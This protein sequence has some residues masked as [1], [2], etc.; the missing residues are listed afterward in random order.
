MFGNL[1]DVPGVQVGH[2]VYAQA[3]TGCTVVLTPAG[4]V[5]GVDVRGSAPGTRETDPLQPGRIVERA[6]AVLLTGGSAYGLAAADGVMRF[7]E[8]RGAGFAVGPVRVPIVPAAVIFDLLVGDPRIRPDAEL[9][10]LACQA[11]GA[12]EMPEGNVG[13]GLGA[14]VGKVFGMEW[15]MKGGLGSCS[16][17]LDSGV[18]VG[19]LAVVNAVGEVRDPETGRP[20][21]GPINPLTGRLADLP[22]LLRSGRGLGNLGMAHTTLAVVATDAALTPP[23]AQKLAQMA[24]TGLARAVY[25]AHTLLDGDVVF[26]LSTGGRTADLNA[27]GAVAADL[28]AAAI[29]RG[30]RAAVGVAGLRDASSRPPLDRDFDPEEGPR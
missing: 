25:P 23:Q 30:V 27:V 24:Q 4:A 19:A 2:A 26:A 18:T 10:Y 20:I 15:A 13:A 8:E 6:H 5:A 16:Q 9:G 3:L 22:R 1:T 7:L 12:G 21:A 28:V 29:A 17:R 11:A 14:T